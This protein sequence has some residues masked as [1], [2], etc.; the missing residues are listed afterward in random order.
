MVELC[1]RLVVALGFVALSWL[2]V[3]S[4]DVGW[5][6]AT[7]L[8]A[9]SLFAWRVDLKGLMNSGVAGFFAIAEAFL[10]A[11]FLGNAGYLDQLG[12]LV[13]A[14]CVFAGAKFGSPML[15]MA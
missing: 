11:L 2:G 3:G 4:F 15:S 5:K 9:I 10:I 8:A 13:L 7:A 12:F 1:V 14:P 6:S